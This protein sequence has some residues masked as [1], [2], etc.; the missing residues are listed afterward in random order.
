MDVLI[1]HK[2]PL[3]IQDGIV[4]YGP[5]SELLLEKVKEVRPSVH[6]FGHIHE[7]YKSFPLPPPLKATLSFEI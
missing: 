3:G 4:M 6:V 7:G 1:T 2:P 5:G